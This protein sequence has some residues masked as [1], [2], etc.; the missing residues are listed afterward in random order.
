LRTIRL[1]RLS[2]SNKFTQLNFQLNYFRLAV[3]IRDQIVKP[4]IG[5]DSNGNQLEADND[6]SVVPLV[7]DNVAKGL[8]FFNHLGKTQNSS[9]NLRFNQRY[10]ENGCKIPTGFPD[11][12]EVPPVYETISITIPIDSEDST[13]YETFMKALAEIFGYLGALERWKRIL[14][15]VCFFAVLCTFGVKVAFCLEAGFFPEDI[16]AEVDQSNGKEDKPGETKAPLENKRVKLPIARSKTTQRQP[17]QQH[18]KVPNRLAR[19]YLKPKDCQQ[20]PKLMPLSPAYRRFYIYFKQAYTSVLNRCNEIRKSIGR[21]AVQDSELIEFRNQIL[22]VENLSN[23]IRNGR[24]AG[25]R[26]SMLPWS[27]TSIEEIGYLS[28]QDIE[29]AFATEPPK[30]WQRE[31]IENEHQKLL[32]LREQQMADNDPELGKTEKLLETTYLLKSLIDRFVRDRETYNAE[33][34]KKWLREH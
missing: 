30:S 21:G 22:T 17:A 27:F 10:D 9:F 16:D 2:K 13:F 6:D 11:G 29:M 1:Q 8:I 28:A 3:Q 5:V 12:I 32:T 34:F 26:D 18:Y 23:D 19:K 20:L 4:I 15:I 7:T 24:E 25:F 31:Y 14:I 33:V